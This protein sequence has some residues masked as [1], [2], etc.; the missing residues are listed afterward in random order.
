MKISTLLALLPLAMAAPARRA[1]PAPVVVPR[2]VRLVEGKYIVKMKGDSNIQSVSSALSSIKA[3]ADHTYTH[4]FHGFAASLSPDE[5]EKLRQ[6]PNVD[7][8]EQDAIVTISNTQTDADWGLSRISSRKAGS[9][10]Y[11]Y[12]KSAGAGTCAF[13]ID[14]GVEDSHPEFEGRAKFLRNFADDG[15]DT[16]G[17]GHGTHVSGTI[18]SRKYGVAKKTRIFGVKVLDAAGSGQNSNVIA[19]MDYVSKEAKNQNCPKGIVVN[20]SLGGS[21]SEAIN[22]AAA[23]I[24]KAG[25]FLAVAAGND[26]IDASYSSPASAPSACTVGATTNIDTLAEYSNIGP[27]VDILAPGSDILSTWIGGTTNIISGTSMASPHVAG[28]GAYFLGKGHKV[29][30]L[31]NYIVQ[32]GVKNVIQDV[33]SGTVN[34]IIN[35][36]M[37]SQ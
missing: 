4:S 5:L 11:T 10:V 17:N 26:G 3:H 8:I 7:F 36:G 34:V 33:P 12:D 24:T 27:I 23:G 37:S 35:N 30:G 1:S 18:G 6:D 21:E 15:D 32:T 19:G 29:N 16:D 22:Q 28:I 2:G 25:L 31:C 9:S 14:T 13:V 20:M